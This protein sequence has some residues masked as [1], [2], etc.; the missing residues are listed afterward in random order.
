MAEA[1]GSIMG[2]VEAHGT[3]PLFVIADISTDEQWM[4]MPETDAPILYLWR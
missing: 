1:E 3:E 2:A 4:S